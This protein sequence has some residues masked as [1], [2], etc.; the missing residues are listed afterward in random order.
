MP[1]PIKRHWDANVRPPANICPQEFCFC[2]V[3]G[4]SQA[5]LSGQRYASVDEA[6]REAKLV[7]VPEGM[8][9]ERGVCT[10]LDSEL[11]DRDRYEPEEQMLEKAGLPWF[12]F[13]ADLTTLVPVRRDEALHW[14]KRLW[15]T[16][17]ELQGNGDGGRG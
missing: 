11:G 15:G 2:W 1:N 8:C 9:M 7:E 3:R 6:L 5:D 13:V 17:R 12:Y 4:G 10:R 16:L 14:A